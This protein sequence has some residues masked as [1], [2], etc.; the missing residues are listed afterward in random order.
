MTILLIKNIH[1]NKPRLEPSVLGRY[2]VSEKKHGN[3]G[4]NSE[5]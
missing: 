1:L 3:S 5:Q 2:T 4:Q